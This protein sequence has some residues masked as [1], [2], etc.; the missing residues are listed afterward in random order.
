V[1]S[2]ALPLLS[3][4]G[5]ESP[6]AHLDARLKILAAAAGAVG[7]LIASDVRQFGSLVLLVAMAA[8]ASRIPPRL[9]WNNLRPVLAFVVIG[10]VL[11]VL[12]TPGKGWHLGNLHLSM[13]GLGLAGRLSAQLIL[14]LAITTLVTYTTPPLAIAGALR[15]LLG[16]LRYVKVPV[17]DMTT[18][19][20]IAITF[21]PIMSRE[22]DRYLTARAAR[23]AS[24]RRLGLF[25][26]LGDL[27]LPLIQANLQRG[28]ELSLALETR[29]Y[30]Y[31]KR[32]HRSD[33]DRI[34]RL[35]AMLSLFAAL[36]IALSLWLL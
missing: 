1:L 21:V 8:V 4:E 29:L 10:G 22:V 27:L 23:G 9:L 3:Y 34:D 11:I 7:V 17:E 20:T 16:F 36:W 14:L 31:A 26:M 12:T 15:R 19:L 18:M 32:S 25:S 28:E 35:S 6:A 33:E 30:G 2:D 5:A 24:V 13:A